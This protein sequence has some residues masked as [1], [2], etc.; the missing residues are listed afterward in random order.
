MED[1]PPAKKKKKTHTK[2]QDFRF[3]FEYIIRHVVPLVV[4]AGNKGLQRRRVVLSP[5]E[6]RRDFSVLCLQQFSGNMVVVLNTT[7]ENRH[8]PS[9]SLHSQCPDLLSLSA[10][11]LKI[12]S[13]DTSFIAGAEGEEDE[14]EVCR[15]FLCRSIRVG[16]SECVERLLQNPEPD[17]RGER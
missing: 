13:L 10:K 12:G 9:L 6:P 5:V 3:Y 7:A 8:R 4:M 2:T 14:D 17:Q 15:I 16:T 11:W 1:Y